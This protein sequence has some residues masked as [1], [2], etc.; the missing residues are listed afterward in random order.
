MFG[1]RERG[2]PGRGEGGGGVDEPEMAGEVH[3]EREREGEVAGN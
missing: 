2:T 1:W 3:G